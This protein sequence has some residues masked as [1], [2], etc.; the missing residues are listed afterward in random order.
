MNAYDK[1]MGS[2]E[3]IKTENKPK[4]QKQHGGG[5][6]KTQ[7]AP[8]KIVEKYNKDSESEESDSDESAGIMR[9]HQTRAR[10]LRESRKVETVESSSSDDE[11]TLRDLT[12]NKR[13]ERAREERNTSSNRSYKPI[14]SGEV[15]GS[16]NGSSE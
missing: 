16:E 7:A 10:V 4:V 8:R 2:A 6:R 12:K 5:S 3:P 9:N 11:E 15:E 1:E 14:P 13:R